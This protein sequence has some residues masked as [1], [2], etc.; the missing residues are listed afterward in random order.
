MYLAYDIKEMRRIEDEIMSRVQRCINNSYC[1][2]VQDV[3]KIVIH[4]IVGK[5]KGSER[6]FSDH[7]INGIWKLYVFLSILL[8][9]FLCR[10]FSLDFMILCTM[11]LIPTC[12]NTS[13]CSL[14]N[15]WAIALSSILRKK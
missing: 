13:L 2:V 15:Y 8:T 7:F 4:S 12:R 10:G 14:S 11:L 3:T 9:L 5:F 1:I 6:L